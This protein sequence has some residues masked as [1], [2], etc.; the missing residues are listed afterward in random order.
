MIPLLDKFLLPQL[1]LTSA[2]INLTENIR[3][4]GLQNWL[5]NLTQFVE[6]F[7]KNHFMIYKINLIH[8]SFGI[9]PVLPSGVCKK[10]KK[11]FLQTRLSDDKK[12]N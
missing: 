7:Y 1:C 6:R 4:T 3:N 8:P 12:T 5:R 9:T 10:L 2:T 11:L